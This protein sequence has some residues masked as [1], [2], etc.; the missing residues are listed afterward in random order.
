MNSIIAAITE[1]ATSGEPNNDIPPFQIPT[2]CATSNYERTI[3]SPLVW[4]HLQEIYIDTLDDPIY[5]E[6]WETFPSYSSYKVAFEV[7]DDGPRGRSI[8][9]AEPIYEGTQVWEDFHS[10]IFKNREEL[11][12]FLQELDHDLQC[13]VLLWAYPEKDHDHVSLALD[14]AS[15]M[16]HGDTE[17]D[18]NLDVDCVALR[19]IDIGEELLGDYSDY[20]EF[21]ND[22]FDW[23]TELRGMAWSE[24]PDAPIRSSSAEEYNLLGAPKRQEI[25]TEN[26][27]ADTPS[28]DAEPMWME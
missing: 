24:Q 12:S 16:N 2:D 26:E 3:H 7:R 8:Y 13:D 22:K 5:A 18:I 28:C 25:A 10:A 27:I 9:A 15:F 19:D 14:P 4:R 1:L 6:K 23:F 20:V 21:S 17:E 11:Q